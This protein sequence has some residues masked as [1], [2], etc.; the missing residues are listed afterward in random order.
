MSI[1]HHLDKTFDLD[2]LK[3]NVDK[4]DTN[5]L[6]AVTDNLNNL[7]S[8]INKIDVDKLS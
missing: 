6:K 2:N 5:E 1:N 4:L 3:S 7:E 8:T